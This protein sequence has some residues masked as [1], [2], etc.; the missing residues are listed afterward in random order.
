MGSLPNR[1]RVPGY[2]ACYRLGGLHRGAFWHSLAFPSSRRESSQ[3][4]ERLN[5][6]K[7]ERAPA[8]NPF[9]KPDDCDYLLE[10][11]FHWSRR[12]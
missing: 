9:A 12:R 10:L 8:L 4:E 6:K 2:V 11:N 1:R 3:R 7:F 5:R